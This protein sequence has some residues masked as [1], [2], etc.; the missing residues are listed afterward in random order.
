[1]AAAVGNSIGAGLGGFADESQME[2]EVRRRVREMERFKLE[3]NC[4]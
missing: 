4:L 2:S 3:L 1:M